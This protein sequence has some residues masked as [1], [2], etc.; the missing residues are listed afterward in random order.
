MN[1]N[2]G[3]LGCYLKR[4]SRP[5]KTNYVMQGTSFFFGDVDSHGG[6]MVVFGPPPL[7]LLQK[8]R[9]ITKLARLGTPRGGITFLGEEPVPLWPADYPAENK[10]IKEIK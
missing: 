9:A 5:L 7:I 10:Q 8:G 3:L 2:R 4:G 1:K 6:A